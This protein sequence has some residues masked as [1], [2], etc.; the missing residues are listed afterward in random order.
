MQTNKDTV[1]TK[2]TNEFAGKYY[3]HQY[4]RIAKHESYRLT[5]SNIVLTLSILIFTFGLSGTQTINVISGLVLPVIVIITNVFSILYFHRTFDYIRVHKKRAKRILE[6]YATDVYKIDQEIKWHR[7][8]A[9]K[10]WNDWTIQIYIHSFLTLI[11]CLP[12]LIYLKIIP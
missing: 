1:E 4:D 11:A 6:L 7:G 10:L 8:L 3:E 9:S 5:N 12:I 2:N